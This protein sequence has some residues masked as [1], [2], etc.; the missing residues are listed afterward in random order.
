MQQGFKV[1]KLLWGFFVL[2]LGMMII[3][4]VFEIGETVYLKTDKE[5]LPRIV[6]S[7][8]VYKLG[9]FYELACG[10]NTSK[11]CDFEISSEINTVL[12]TT[13]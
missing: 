13:N 12:T 1:S 7:I 4:T 9:Y 2:P 8:T 5:Q 3:D 10:V 6:Y 11:H